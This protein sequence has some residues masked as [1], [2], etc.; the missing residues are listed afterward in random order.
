MQGTKSAALAERQQAACEKACT[1]P[2]SEFHPGNPELFRT[3]TLW[4]YFERL[5]REEPVHFLFDKPGGQLLVSDQIHRHHAR[6]Y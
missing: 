3:D 6:R 4:P 5:R 1:T 2:L